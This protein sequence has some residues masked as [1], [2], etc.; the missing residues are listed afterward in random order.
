MNAPDLNALRLAA[1]AATIDR[2]RA[3]EAEHGIS[4]PALEAINAELLTLAAQE[5]LFPFATFP[6]RQPAARALTAT[7]CSR[8]PTSGSRCISTR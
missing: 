4:R 6:P 7:C 8:T 1:I 3:I 2:V 5:H